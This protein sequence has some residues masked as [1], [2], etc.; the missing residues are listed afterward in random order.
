M[1]VE[2]QK[3]MLGCLD[4]SWAHASWNKDYTSRT[5]LQLR[6]AWWGEH[7]MCATPGHCLTRNGN[8]LVAF[9]PAVEWCWVLSY[10]ADKGD[11]ETRQQGLEFPT[12]SH[13]RQ[14]S[15]RGWGT[16]VSACLISAHV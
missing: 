13:Y 4:F 5:P 7:V 8:D 16:D 9:P 2:V 14:D 15:P 12:E 11:S 10:Q 3:G 1:L 6:F